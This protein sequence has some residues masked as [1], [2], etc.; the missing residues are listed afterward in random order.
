VQE[1]KRLSSVDPGSPAEVRV[2]TDVLGHVDD[3]AF[4]RSCGD[5]VGEV[6]SSRPSGVVRAV[7]DDDTRTEG[8]HLPPAR[9]INALVDPVPSE[10]FHPG[11]RIRSPS[12]EAAHRTSLLAQKGLQ[13]AKVLLDQRVVLGT[14]LGSLG[15]RRLELRSWSLSRLRLERGEK[16]RVLSEQR[17]GEGV[18]R[19][20]RKPRLKGR[21]VEGHQ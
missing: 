19:L 14:Y 7:P 20:G 5:A 15:V 16:S 11:E 10:P 8:L 6:A 13:Q 18:G 21:G 2:E 3:P 1:P 12:A 9:N 4:L 17:V